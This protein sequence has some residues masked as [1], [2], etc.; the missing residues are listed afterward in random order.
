MLNTRN[1][2]YIFTDSKEN[3]VNDLKEKNRKY[4]SG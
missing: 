4:E 1:W 2:K 3:I